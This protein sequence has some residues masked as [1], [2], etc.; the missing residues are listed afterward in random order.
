MMKNI[1]S[2]VN[3]FGSLEKAEKILME[4]KEKQTGEYQKSEEP[5]KKL[6]EKFEKHQ[7]QEKSLRGLANT[8]GWKFNSKTIKQTEGKTVAKPKV[9]WTKID[10]DE[11]GNLEPIINR[12][13]QIDEE[14]KEIKR[15]KGIIKRKEGKEPPKPD[16]KLFL[17]SKKRQAILSLADAEKNLE[18]LLEK[19][20]IFEEK[21]EKQN[22]KDD[23]EEEIEKTIDGLMKRIEKNN[24]RI[25]DTEDE[26]ERRI[27]LKDK[28][29]T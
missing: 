3:Q 16:Q 22:I 1:I 6:K 21:T 8:K 15:L 4:E 9:I 10:T 26:L 28:G 14:I 13:K 18:K 20:K 25:K 27:K 12:F 29:N 7:E 24:K 5:Y 2:L 19:R 17:E 11:M 23:G